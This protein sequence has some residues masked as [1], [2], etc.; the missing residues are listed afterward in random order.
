M[1]RR[2]G[3]GRWAW[4]AGR[5]W[6]GVCAGRG[7]QG[8]CRWAWVVAGRVPLAG[9]ADREGEGENGPLVHHELVLLL[10]EQ[11]LAQLAALKIP[12]LSRAGTRRV[13]PRPIAKN[14]SRRGVAVA[15]TSTLLKCDF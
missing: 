15:P 4:A 5:G 11:V 12:N 7:W 14:D 9:F 6:Q 3:A 2:T 10:V 1:G 13:C 8:V